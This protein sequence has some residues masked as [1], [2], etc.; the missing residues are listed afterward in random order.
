MSEE[1]DD[2]AIATKDMELDSGNMMMNAVLPAK[3]AADN[4]IYQSKIESGIVDEEETENLDDGASDA[5][6]KEDE[7]V[8]GNSD[9]VEPVLVDK[10]PDEETDS[11][12]G[13]SRKNPALVIVGQNHKFNVRSRYLSNSV[14][15]C[16]DFCKYGHK[17][18]SEKK[19]KRLS[20]GTIRETQ[21]LVKTT[22]N[23]VG[24]S[25]AEKVNKKKDL[26]RRLSLPGP[27]PEKSPVMHVEEKSLPKNDM[28][29]SKMKRIQSE[30]KP[31]SNPSTGNPS[32]IK[33]DTQS[34]RKTAIQSSNS[35]EKPAR[36]V[37]EIKTGKEEGSCV[38][39][40]KEVKAKESMSSS[41]E[42]SVKKESGSSKGIRG[43][44]AKESMSNSP[45]TP[46]K[47]S[48]SL[49]A[50][51]Y[52]SRRSSSRSEIQINPEEVKV[53]VH[54]DMPEKTLYMIEAN[55]NTKPAKKTSNASLLGGNLRSTTQ[56][57]DA[58]K[59]QGSNDGNR[60][61]SGFSQLS[62]SS[63]ESSQP[64]GE[65]QQGS[66]GTKKTGVSRK[67]QIGDKTEDGGLKTSTA[68]VKSAVSQRMKNLDFKSTKQTEPIREDGRSKTNTTRAKSTVEPKSKPKRKEK[69]QPEDKDDSAWKVKFK[70]GTVV[71]LQV[72]NNAPKK[73]RFRRRSFGEDNNAKAG[74]DKK[75]RNKYDAGNEPNNAKPEQE[76]VHLRHQE[77]SEKKDDVDLNNVIEETASKLVKT[78]K[79]KVKALV[80]AFETVMSLRDHKRLVDTNAS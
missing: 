12:A 66:E 10:F 25:V 44:K 77:A 27:V 40:E 41:P 21:P 52:R 15:S 47:K 78:R 20:L 26:N 5:A 35:Q 9:I 46:L 13:Q 48:P 50:R 23:S 22:N 62:S 49:K 61:G 3:E 60:R 69:S 72:A 75:L 2:N 30:I 68:R 17:H 63:Q 58:S 39:G 71:A 80:G 70:R 37:K 42:K 56:K 73:L 65:K 76:K 67:K 33:T 31:S 14:S 38:E 32:R 45:K 6:I 54:D 57:T 4:N 53:D 34:V 8:G 79:S 16:H 11:A 74:T 1:N 28:S 36:K 59:S 7:Y 19:T 51:L 43:I 64:R 24:K 29:R 55:T 18:D